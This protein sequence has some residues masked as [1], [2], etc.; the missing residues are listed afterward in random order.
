MKRFWDKVY[1]TERCWVWVGTRQKGGY[2]VFKLGESLFF[3]HRVCHVMTKGP[4]PEGQVVRHTCDNP[5]CVRPNHLVLGTQAQNMMDKNERGRNPL[6]GIRTTHCPKGHEYAAPEHKYDNEGKQACRTCRN[7]RARTAQVAK[8][9]VS[10]A[11]FLPAS[12]T[13]KKAPH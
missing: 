4:I 13:L 5:F 6:V 12:S 2:G 7:E 9:A 3:A 8:R 11:E 1:K 10:K